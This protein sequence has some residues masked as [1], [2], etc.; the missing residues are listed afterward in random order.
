MVKTNRLVL[1]L[2]FPHLGSW[3][4][5]GLPEPEV[6]LADW[7][8]EELEDQINKILGVED[9]DYEKEDDTKKQSFVLNDLG[10]CDD[11]DSLN[12]AAP[13]I[14]LA[15]EKP[16]EDDGASIS[17][18]TST[19]GTKNY[20]E[21]QNGINYYEESIDTHCTHCDKQFDEF[22]LLT[23]H[24]TET[25][26]EENKFKFKCEYCPWKAA[27][28]KSH[29]RHEHVH[30]KDMIFSCDIC[31]SSFKGFGRF[32]RH[33]QTH[34]DSN[35]VG[36]EL[37]KKKLKSTFTLERHIRIKHKPEA[38]NAEYICELCSARLKTKLKLR[39][40][41]KRV[42]ASRSFMCAFCDKCF[43][44]KGHLTE[45]EALHGDNASTECTICG[46]KMRNSRRNIRSHMKTHYK[47]DSLK[48]EKCEY[49]FRSQSYL[50]EHDT[51][52]H[53]N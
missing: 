51:I 48:C 14:Y 41:I 44:T 9:R 20:V 16:E 30:T 45:H 34:L 21:E 24:L 25:H 31:S 43:K 10:P 5:F 6:I 37:C 17:V 3:R 35:L 38:E 33:K 53:K 15:E 49:Y 18:K 39:L 40:H 11:E 22:H 7:G 32:K 12:D 2:I 36:C 27:T 46:F 8:A 50:L 47:I 52:A 42:H 29:E 23:K 26:S 13:G 4:G 19:T 28:K 1:G